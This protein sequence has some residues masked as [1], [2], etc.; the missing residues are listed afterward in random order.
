[1]IADILVHD[2]QARTQFRPHGSLAENQRINAAYLVVKNTLLRQ[3]GT[4]TLEQCRRLYGLVEDVVRQSFGPGDT[5]VHFT[6]ELPEDPDF[7]P[8]VG[9]RIQRHFVFDFAP[10][11]I[12]N[13][14]EATR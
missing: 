7:M 11:P 3:A 4:L 14:G 2:D 5:P 12:V 9:W 8:V 10:V 13:A 1:L 6:I